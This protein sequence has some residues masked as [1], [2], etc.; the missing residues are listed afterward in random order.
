VSSPAAG[1][2]LLTA[3]VDVGA[4]NDV[5]DD[6]T[7][8]VVFTFELAANG[9]WTFTLIDQLDH[10]D[11]GVGTPGPAVIDTLS[12]DLSSA[13]LFS[14]FDGDTIELAG[15]LTINVVDDVPEEFHPDH[16]FVFNDDQNGPGTV[17]TVGL[18]FAAA[19]GADENGDVRFK[20]SNEG[21]ALDANGNEITFNDGINGPM[22]LYIF[23]SDD[24][25]TLRATTD[26]DGLDASQDVYTIVL[27]PANDEYTFTMIRET[28]FNGSEFEFD[29]VD[30]VGGGNSAFKG[31]IGAGPELDALIS[32]QGN[33]ANASDSNV[34][35]NNS[36]IGIGD[37]NSIE[38]D[39]IVRFDF[40][41]DLTATPG[42]TTSGFSY[43]TRATSTIFRQEVTFV[44]P[45]GGGTATASFIVTAYFDDDGDQI[46]INDGTLRTITGVKIFDANG[47]EI[48]AADWLANGITV[49]GIGTT[50]VD[51][52]G[53]QAGWSYQIE[54]SLPFTAVQVEGDDG[55]DFKLGL[56]SIFAQTAGEPIPLEYDIVGNDFDGDEVS[57]TLSATIVPDGDSNN[58][59]G[60][61][62]DDVHTDTSNDGVLIAGL[63]G[64]D[65]LTGGTGDD[66][67][68]GGDGNDILN[69]GDGDDLL[70]GGDGNDT[71]DGGA[72][73]DILDGGEG[74]DQLTG[75]LGADTFVFTTAANDLSIDTV[76][77]Y[78][79]NADPLLSDY[80][81]LTALFD[82]ATSGGGGD[83]F[84]DFVT[85]DDVTGELFVDQDGSGAGE[86]KHIAT[87]T[88]GPDDVRIIFT[89]TSTPGTDTTIV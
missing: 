10:P 83:T 6:G 63:Q 37:G 57:S 21:L 16:A 41:T 85:Y 27:D 12:L 14:D 20:E 11:P 51:F 58:F 84:A 70:F 4:P 18:D 35:T 1:V 86:A 50:A 15:A 34:N 77:D 78:T 23:V 81:D 53:I 24:G 52:G 5:F 32:G 89:D 31:I 43:T 47:N 45:A 36:D 73:N 64:D 49:D 80:V 66:Q 9:D 60:T 71:L 48:L 44:S 55:N 19:V 40:F 29:A 87:L 25:H 3:F 61:S 7:D 2:Y 39:E 79:F 74:A 54:T 30:S 68:Y 72:G 17:T 56:F 76:T 22:P 88:G 69:G 65:T 28:V 67:I 62:G 8:R 42:A 82:V 33:D 46:F 75:G 26:P 13:I 59:I 38:T